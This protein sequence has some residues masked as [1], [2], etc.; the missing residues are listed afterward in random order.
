MSF[1]SM[2]ARNYS[3]RS[4]A[5]STTFAVLI[6]GGLLGLLLI[7]DISSADMLPSEESYPITLPDGSTHNLFLEGTSEY[8][9]EVDENGYTVVECIDPSLDQMSRC[10][11]KLN[12]STGY[13]ESTGFLLGSTDPATIPGLETREIST[14]TR[15]LEECGA[16][17]D[18]MEDD[19]AN[20][21]MHTISAT[22][23]ANGLVDPVGDIFFQQGD[24]VTFSFYPSYCLAESNPAKIGGIEFGHFDADWYDGVNDGIPAWPGGAVTKDHKHEYDI[25]TGFTYVDYFEPHLPMFKNFASPNLSNLLNP[26]TKF[27]I[28]VSNG[29]I[30]TAGFLSINT[31]FISTNPDTYVKVQDY[32]KIAI[33]DLTVYSLSGID[34]TTKLSSLQL[35]FKK[36]AIA[37]GPLGILPTVTN[38]VKL[39]VPGSHSEWR[40]GALT[41]QLVEVDPSGN[42]LFTVDPR[43]SNSTGPQGP[44]NGT[45]SLLFEGTVF[46]HW[47]GKSPNCAGSGSPYSCATYDAEGICSAG[48]PT[49]DDEYETFFETDH[50]GADCDGKGCTC[51]GGCAGLKEL[52]D[53]LVDGVSVGTP[54][55][56]HFHNITEDHTVHAVFA[57]TGTC[58]TIRARELSSSSTPPNA[59][60]STP[61]YESSIRHGRKLSAITTGTLQ[62]LAILFKFSDHDARTVPSRADMDELMNGGEGIYK[63]ASYNQLDIQTTV[64][65]WVTLDSL[66]TQSYCA[67]QKS[68]KTHVLHQCLRNALDKVDLLGTINWPLFDSN[69]DLWID[70]IAFFH[71]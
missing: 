58:P 24:E 62:N 20:I 22:G 21:V 36:D 12:N 69:Q 44:V 53:V 56:Y 39:N 29:D 8:N 40:N 42:D 65:E 68:G 57:T 48:A 64:T 66:Y 71:R 18:D 1:P 54:Q 7:A 41:M 47:G 19:R 35:G 25:A 51:P 37:R 50:Y 32:D 23:T 6:I 9:Y 59:I 5:E 14:G 43:L 55:H 38:E 70:S 4:S 11:G 13:V 33:D 61:L 28:V 30:N 67:G 45:S 3:R 10:Y 49:W 31:Q 60:S 15:Q 63:T 34:G 52:C 17:C 27:K 2:I 16:F 26:N 46:W